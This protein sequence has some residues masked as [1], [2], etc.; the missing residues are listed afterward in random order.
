MLCLFRNVGQFWNYGDQHH[1]ESSYTKDK[2]IFDTC[3]GFDLF[4][5]HHDCDV[6]GFCTTFVNGGTCTDGYHMFKNKSMQIDLNNWDLM[7]ASITI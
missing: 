2:N 4:C 5:E 1:N 6:S 7:A 3:M